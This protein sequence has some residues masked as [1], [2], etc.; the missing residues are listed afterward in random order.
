MAFCLPFHDRVDERSAPSNLRLYFECL[1]NKREGVMEAMFIVPVDVTQHVTALDAIPGL[2]RQ[3][4]A[5]SRIDGVLHSIPACSQ[6][7]RRQPQELS[8]ASCHEAARSGAKF[9]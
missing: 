7:V 6:G 1:L 9:L 8:I 2:L 4:Q 3:I 5:Y